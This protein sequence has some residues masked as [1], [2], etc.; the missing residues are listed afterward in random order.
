MENDKLRV[1][2]FNPLTNNQSIKCSPFLTVT[3]HYFSN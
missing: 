3:R 2:F 1:F